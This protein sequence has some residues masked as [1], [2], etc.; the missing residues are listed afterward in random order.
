MFNASTLAV[1]AI[2][3]IGGAISMPTLIKGFVRRGTGVKYEQNFIIQRAPQY[4]SLANIALL[5][6]SFMV[7]N[8][9]ITVPPFQFF[10]FAMNDADPTVRMVSWLGVPILISGMIF[11]VG[12]WMSLGES[13]STD[14][15]VLNDHKVKNT[16]L[17]AY[18][19][20]PAYSGIIQCLLGASI[21][22]TSVIC[23]VWCL[24]VVAPLWL[25]RAKYEERLLIENLGQPYKEYA[26]S[27][28]WRR[29]VPKFI[30]IGV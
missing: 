10:A 15:E 16:G 30:P 13:F 2:V 3:L 1:M 19:M 23:V 20:H 22:A 5:I 26:D 8:N 6:I 28:K 24:G 29:F 18:V 9:I 27:M 11:M 14:A 17:L 25:K 12:G 7:F 21:A 4:A